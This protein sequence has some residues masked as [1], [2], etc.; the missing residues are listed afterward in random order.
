[1]AT[2]KTDT[3]SPISR[4]DNRLV[5]PTRVRQAKNVGIDVRL[6]QARRAFASLVA[7]AESMPM[8]LR[9][10]FDLASLGKLKTGVLGK[11]YLADEEAEGR[12]GF[13]LSF[14]YQGRD[15]I[16]HRSGAGTQCAA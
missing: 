8:Q 3:T 11:F 15:G 1:M 13:T 7:T 9:A 12:I 10:E 5:S 4:V 2:D 16:K 14:E 6:N